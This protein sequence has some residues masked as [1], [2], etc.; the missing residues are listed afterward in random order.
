MPKKM[1]MPMKARG[2]A[3]GGMARGGVAA[4]GVGSTVGQWIEDYV[5]GWLGFANGGEMPANRPPEITDAVLKELRKDLKAD[6][7]SGDLEVDVKAMARGGVAAAGVGATVGQWVE[8][9]IMS[10]FAQ[11]GELPQMKRGGQSVFH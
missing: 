9:W 1:K 7:K 3:R 2:L 4:A 11:G 8:D 5:L 6:I 10:F